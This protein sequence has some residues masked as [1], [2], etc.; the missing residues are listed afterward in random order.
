MLR[1]WDNYA[2]VC[3]FFLFFFFYESRGSEKVKTVD[4]C[5]WPTVM[6]GGRWGEER[7]QKSCTTWPVGGVAAD[8]R[9]TDGSEFRCCF[10]CVVNIHLQRK[11]KMCSRLLGLV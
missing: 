11:L 3:L 8:E 9:A 4:D 10:M 6:G 7:E 1:Q 2:I 5:M